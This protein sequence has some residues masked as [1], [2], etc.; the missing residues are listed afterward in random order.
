MDNIKRILS[1]TRRAV[2]DYQMI[3]P[4]DKIAVGISGGKDSL[5][6]L[7]AL[8][9]LRRFYPIPFEVVAVTIGLRVRRKEGAEL[10][11]RD[12]HGEARVL[13]LAVWEGG[14]QREH[15]LFTEEA[16]PPRG[17]LRGIR[18]RTGKDKARER[19]AFGRC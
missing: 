17:F 10:L 15:R 12:R 19:P 6:L 3:R 14:L 4:G 9:E 18:K 1:F 13:D 7:C 11:L 5:T 8:A 2:D 16:K